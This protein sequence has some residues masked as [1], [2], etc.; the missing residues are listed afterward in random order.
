[1]IT[2]SKAQDWRTP[3]QVFAALHREYAFTI[4]AAAGIGNNLLPRFW[5]FTHNA[6]AHSLEGERAFCNPPFGM[7]YD[8]LAWGLD[9]AA[10]GFSCFLVPANQETDWF[11]DLAVHGDKHIFKRRVEYVPPRGVDVS[12]PSFSSMLVMFGPGVVSSGLG[13]SRRRDGKTGER[14]PD[15]VTSPRLGGHYSRDGRWIVDEIAA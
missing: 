8:F 13:F 7:I 2:K 4:D 6:L 14:L 9:E 10:G 15:P 11:H 3:P 12:S 1:M 5:T